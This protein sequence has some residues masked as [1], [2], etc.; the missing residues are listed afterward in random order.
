[1]AAPPPGK[2]PALLSPTPRPRPLACSTYRGNHTCCPSPHPGSSCHPAAAWA[3][4]GL[5]LCGHQALSGADEAAL[6][7]WPRWEVHTQSST[8]RDPDTSQP[9]LT[10]L[11]TMK[12]QLPT[13]T[14]GQTLSCAGLSQIDLYWYTQQHGWISQTLSWGKEASH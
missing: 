6:R 12:G 2:L 9:Q 14:H 10:T 1:M 4:R 11:E 8:P 5:A 3:K 7:P 13:E